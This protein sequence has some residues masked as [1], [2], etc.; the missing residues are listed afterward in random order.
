MLALTYLSKMYLLSILFLCSLVSCLSHGKLI[1]TLLCHDI[2]YT[3][4]TLVKVLPPS[5]FQL[6]LTIP[7]VGQVI[8]EHPL[9]LLIPVNTTAVFTCKADCAGR[10]SNIYWHIDG[11][12]LHNPQERSQ[13][14][15]IF[16][17][18]RESENKYITML[19]V[20]ATEAINNTDVYCVFEKSG[21]NDDN[22]HSLTA[23]LLVVAGK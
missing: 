10:C 4:I 20:N 17:V 5:L 16:S 12:D 15:F 13:T 14:G 6:P 19:S 2:S 18:D 21:D 8:E 7:N 22:N 9:S 11:N 3:L 1:I 23:T